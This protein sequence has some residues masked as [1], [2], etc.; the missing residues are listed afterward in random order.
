MALWSTETTAQRMPSMQQWTAWKRAVGC[1]EHAGG[2][3]RQRVAGASAA[4]GTA[5][6]SCL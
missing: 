3:S 6:Q 2:L 4:Q 5:Q 1:E